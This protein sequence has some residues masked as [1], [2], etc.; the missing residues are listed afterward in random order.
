MTKIHEIVL[1]WARSLGYLVRDG[2]SND[3]LI[4][5]ESDRKYLI[6]RSITANVAREENASYQSRRC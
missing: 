5:G 1:N 4:E 2:R 3:P 6:E